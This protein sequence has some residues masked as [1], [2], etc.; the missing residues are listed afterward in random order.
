MSDNLNQMSKEDQCLGVAQAFFH[1]L[2][3]LHTNMLKTILFL[4]S[5]FTQTQ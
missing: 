3:I 5:K 1:L 4:T 2:K